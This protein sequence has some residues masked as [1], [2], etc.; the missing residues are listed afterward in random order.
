MTY[1]AYTYYYA[2]LISL[3]LQLCTIHTVQEM[4]TESPVCDPEPMDS[5]DMLFI[6]YTSGTAG[7]SHP[8]YHTQAG[9]LLYAA[10]TFKVRQQ[11]QNVHIKLAGQS[12]VL[13]A[14]CSET[15]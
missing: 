11:L 8:I 1:I 4:A 10:V 6:L 15:C 7:I 3:Q 12:L 13:I 2:V 9:Y 14:K 5:E